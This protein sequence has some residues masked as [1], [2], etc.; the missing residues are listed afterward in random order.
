MGRCPTT[1]LMLIDNLLQAD[2]RQDDGTNTI[3]NWLDEVSAQQEPIEST[4]L[5]SC[6]KILVLI[7]DRVICGH[8]SAKW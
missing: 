3:H 6:Y 7:E 4:V 1:L 2:H 8:Y 5:V